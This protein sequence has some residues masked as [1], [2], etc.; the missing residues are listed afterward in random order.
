MTDLVYPPVIGLAR[1]WFK[2]LDMRITVE[3][4]P[5]SPDAWG[6]NQVDVQGSVISGNAIWMKSKA[7]RLRSCDSGNRNGS[8]RAHIRGVRLYGGQR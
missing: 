6:L 4:G 2:A 7:T 3:G 5:G 1:G 8:S